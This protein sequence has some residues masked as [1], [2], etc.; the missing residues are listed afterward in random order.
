MSEEREECVDFADSVA[1]KQKLLWLDVQQ[2]RRE[3]AEAVEAEPE[4]VD[5]VEF[6]ELRN[7]F[8]SVVVCDDGSNRRRERRQQRKLVVG[9]SSDERGCVGEKRD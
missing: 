5:A 2:S 7:I 9:K 8:N 3:A 4:S 1:G 6:S